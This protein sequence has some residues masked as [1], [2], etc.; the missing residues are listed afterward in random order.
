M[1]EFGKKLSFW[2]HWMIIKMRHLVM[3]ISRIAI[4]LVYFW[5]GLLKVLQ[6][7]PASLLVVSLLDRTMP[8][9]SPE[10]FLITFG[11][12][13]MIIG[14]LFII[15]HLERLAVFALGLHLIT[16]IMPLFLLPQATWQGFLTPTLEGQYIIKNI[17]IIALA[18]GILAHL[19]TFEELNKPKDA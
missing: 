7:S 5:F 19:H 8:S 3:P 12:I 9:I 4:F 11:V 14:L 2:D 17:L 6:T 18:I 13:E 16:T 15:P 1:K 10:S